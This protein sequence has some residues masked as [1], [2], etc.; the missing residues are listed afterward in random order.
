MNIPNTPYN[1]L[2]KAKHGTWC[3]QSADKF[4]AAGLREIGECGEDETQLLC[5]LVNSGDTVIDCG[6]NVGLRTIPLSKK[7]TNS[8]YVFAFEPE[9]I[10]FLNLCANIA[11][12]SC[13]SAYPM[14]VAIGK[15][16]G[17]VVLGTV[18]PWN[19]DNIGLIDLKKTSFE[20]G[21]AVPVV[22]LDQFGLSPSL[23]KIDVEGMECDVLEGAIKTIE[24]CRPY[25]FC[26]C[27]DN[28]A[29][30]R[31]ADCIQHL[32]YDGFYFESSLW[33]DDNFN[34]VKENKFTDAVSP[35]VL[36]VPKGK[37]VP[38]GLM[39]CVTTGIKQ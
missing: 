36:F 24:R 5:S 37:Q 38:A 31:Q 27:F 6:A 12:N 9:R 35:N 2:I 23:I 14:N 33:K 3:I 4:M 7:V 34:G 26:E 13:Y 22:P 21:F 18:D 39:H 8:G 19:C 25:L 15:T 29:L 16:H 32:E 10:N 17:E 20:K 11:I 30:Q 1:E 28:A